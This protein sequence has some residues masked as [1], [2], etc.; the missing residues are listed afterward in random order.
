MSNY[1]VT[2]A[3]ARCDENGKSSGGKPGDQTAN[4][5]HTKGELKFEDWYISGDSW[6]FVLRGK[7]AAI[8][9]LMPEDACKAVRNE[10]IG[11]SQGARYTLYDSVR[12]L[13][14]DCGLVEK[15]VDC[16][17]SSLMT[18]CANYAGVAIP[19]DTRTATMKT[20]YSNTKMFKMYTSN[21][22]VKS[23]D[24]LKVGD[25][26][27]R[28]GHHTAIVVNTLYHMTRQLRYVAGNIMKGKD[29]KALQT[30]LNELGVV[31][32]PL[33]ED[34]ELG[35][36]TDAAIKAYQRQNDLEI[37]GIMGRHTAEKLGFLW[38]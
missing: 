1:V 30:R 8:R 19:R 35:K 2:I 29:V 34:G 7:T 21:K 4:K 10:H 27:V 32:I 28:A 31:D 22:Y 13:V 37:D 17:C 16:D 3:H 20:A 14:F 5:E 18:V 15:N 12:I 23:S 26:L 11:Y 24:K 33:E 25:I 9:A 38:D 36:L 6:D